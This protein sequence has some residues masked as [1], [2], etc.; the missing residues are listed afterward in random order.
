MIEAKWLPTP[1]ALPR[2]GSILA[3]PERGNSLT[4]LATE[5]IAL[6]AWTEEEVPVLYGAVT[7][8]QD[9]RFCLFEREGRRVVVDFKLY[10]VPEETEVLLRILVG[11]LKGD[12]FELR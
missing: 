11:I 8:G 2:R 12:V 4:R 9:W 10:R 3:E 1:S 7:T 5:L 6:D